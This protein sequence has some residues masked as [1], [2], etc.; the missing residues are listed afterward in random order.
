M[1]AIEVEES[2]ETIE[3]MEAMEWG[4][5]PPLGRGTG[6]RDQVTQ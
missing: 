2:L 1:E 6:F 5:I 3:T 4:L